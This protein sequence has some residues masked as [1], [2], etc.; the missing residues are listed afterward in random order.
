[1]NKCV[2]MKQDQK[3]RDNLVN[4]TYFWKLNKSLEEKLWKLV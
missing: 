1:M 4:D 2:E 3:T